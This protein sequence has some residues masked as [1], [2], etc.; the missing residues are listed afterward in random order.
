M[1]YKKILEQGKKE[2]FSDLEFQI[3]SSTSL[4]IDVF[5][6]KVDKNQV[7]SDFSIVLSG[8][9]KDQLASVST[10]NKDFDPKKLLKKLK[11]NEGFK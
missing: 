4:S 9:Y 7:H 3:S 10:T 5:K 8:L 6:G 11:E 1:D 2:G